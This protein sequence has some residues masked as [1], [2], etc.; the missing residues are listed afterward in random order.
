MVKYLTNA[1]KLHP[2]KQNGDLLQYCTVENSNTFNFCRRWD[3]D[4]K[5]EEIKKLK[6]VFSIDYIL[7][8]NSLLTSNIFFALPITLPKISNF[9]ISC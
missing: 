1:L 5:Q 9:Y 2:Q 7:F 4:I 6:S 3:I 8:M